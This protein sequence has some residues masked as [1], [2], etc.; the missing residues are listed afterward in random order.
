MNHPLNNIGWSA[1]RDHL[2][3]TLSLASEYLEYKLKAAK[4]EN[5]HST[6]R[7]GDY[8]Y[9]ETNNLDGFVVLRGNPDFDTPGNTENPSVFICSTDELKH[10]VILTSLLNERADKSA[11]LNKG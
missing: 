11:A 6:S 8:Y 7:G 2:N 3:Q 9:A 4:Q 1:V 5:T 10:A